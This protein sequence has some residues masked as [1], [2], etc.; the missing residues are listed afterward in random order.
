M[1]E[2]FFLEDLYITDNEA[3][4]EIQR[5]STENQEKHRENTDRRAENLAKARVQVC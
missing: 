1:V 4:E 3:Y 5:T 2:I